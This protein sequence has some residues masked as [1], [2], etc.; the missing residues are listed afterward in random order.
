MSAAMEDLSQNPRDDYDEE[1]PDDQQVESVLI[2]SVDWEDALGDW[3][4]VTDV[5]TFEDTD[6]LTTDR[7]IKIKC[8]NGQEVYLTIQVQPSSW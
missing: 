2:D 8:D 3:G 7:G 6:V 4:M 5:R 1:T